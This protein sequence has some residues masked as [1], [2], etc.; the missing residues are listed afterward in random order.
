MRWIRGLR[1]PT[2][3]G[4]LGARP[5][6]VFPALLSFSLGLASCTDEPTR[7]DLGGGD[8]GGSRTPPRVLGLVEVTISG[9]GTGQVTSSALS[10]PTLEALERL[11]AE[12][13][14]RG[15]G[16]GGLASQAFTLPDHSEGGGDGTIQFELLSTGSFTGGERGKGGYRYLYTTYRV[17]NAQATDSTPYDTPRK[18]L[19]F[20]AVSTKET[21]GHAPI[22]RLLRFDGTPADPALAEQFIP[23]GGIT[24]DLSAGGLV[25]AGPD[26]LQV[27]TEAEADT[28]EALAGEG[29]EDVFPYGFMVRRVGSTTTRE[30][31]ANPAPD[32]FDGIVT[33]AYKVPLQETPAQDPFTVSIMFLAVDDDEVRITQSLEEQTSAGQQA[34]QARAASLGANVLTLLPPE[35][36]VRQGVPGKARMLCDVRVAGAAGSGGTRLA[37]APAEGVWL[38]IPPRVAWA[39]ALPGTVRLTAASC[40][41]IASVDATSFVVYGF[42][43]GRVVGGA[44]DGVGSS[45]VHAPTGPNGG[46]FPGEEVEVTLTTGL[47]RTKPL[48]AR[49]RIAA[50]GGSGTFGGATVENVA[51]P[52]RVVAAGDL[53]GDGALDLAVGTDYS[54]VA[55]LLNKGDGSFDTYQP[56]SVNRLLRSLALGDLDG[57]GDLDVVTGHYF[58]KRLSVLRN[59]GNGTFAPDTLYSLG[60]SQAPESIALGDLDGDGDLDIAVAAADPGRLLVFFNQDQRGTFGPA[61]PYTVGNSQS[62]ALGDLDGDG[63]LDMVVTTNDSDN[64]AVL[65][66]QGNGTFGNA[67]LYSVGDKQRALALGDV[68]GDGDLDA[69]VGKNNATDVLVLLN[70]G[71]GT[72]GSQIAS[73]LGGAGPSAFALGDLDADGDLDLVATYNVSSSIP[74]RVALNQGN[75]VFG[76]LTSY[77]YYYAA[78]F[79]ALGDLDGDGDL[80]MVTTR[81]GQYTVLIMRN[82]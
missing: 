31:P 3:T 44:Y 9:L 14:A 62:V 82:Q 10:A 46:F 56:Y 1:C 30:L 53:N 52:S 79:V 36:Y 22:V 80:D 42:Q 6:F 77:P 70:R 41:S 66:N 43:S 12:R 35:G 59:Q 75:G 27:L 58:D 68:D 2:A 63:D 78:P 8:E 32:Q 73:D 81:P 13:D 15:A 23:T 69:V 25:S 61:V 47:G 29:V 34:F 48:V 21:I 16:S 33:F 65:L 26:V 74:I 72:F 18:N 24:H 67:V 54:T 5:V 28:V 38:G 7:P 40:S 49:Y 45:F 51:A 71:D 60:D 50:T 64:V 57:D 17:R 20:Y 76:S 11:R 19:T 39:Q 37:P 4:R 55:V